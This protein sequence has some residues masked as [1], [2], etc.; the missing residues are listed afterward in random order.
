MTFSVLKCFRDIQLPQKHVRQLIVKR[1]YT[2]DIASSPYNV[3]KIF[4]LLLGDD[5][6]IFILRLELKF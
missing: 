1:Y 4:N 2:I 5:F 3:Y 6:Y